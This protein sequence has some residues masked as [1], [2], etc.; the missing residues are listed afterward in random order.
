M[1]AFRQFRMK[2]VFLQG[3]PGPRNPAFQIQQN[4]IQIDA[5]RLDQGTDRILAG[6]GI[7]SR[8]RTKPCRAN[9]LTVKLRQAIDRLDLQIRRGMGLTIPF[10]IFRHVAQPEIGRKIDDFQIARQGLD[11]SLAG[12][13][14][15]RA[16]GQINLCK[17]DLL[18]FAKLRQGKMAQ[19]G[20]DL[21]HLQPR[22]AIRRQGDDLHLWMAGNQAHQFGPRI[23]RCPKDRDALFHGS[24]LC[25]FAP[26]LCGARAD[27]AR[28][29]AIRRPQKRSCDA[30]IAW[31]WTK[32]RPD[33][34]WSGIS[35]PD[36]C[37]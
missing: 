33:R 29:M 9:I 4:I 18:N 3:P 6:R 35:R 25:R 13:M 12:G 1:G 24:P 7:A 23:A 26:F 34:P 36:H 5:A 11:D 20:K 21:G 22:L 14:G 28:G 31:P 30:G 27:D 2:Q 16:K 10:F 15:Q 19:K 32:H 8:A 17:I 37:P